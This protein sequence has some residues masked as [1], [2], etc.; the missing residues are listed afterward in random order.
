MEQRSA[1]GALEMHADE[2][3]RVARSYSARF[4]HLHLLP[5]HAPGQLNSGDLPDGI[6]QFEYHGLDVTAVQDQGW[7]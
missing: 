2:I 6:R 7:R 5:D 3:R 1:T 4:R